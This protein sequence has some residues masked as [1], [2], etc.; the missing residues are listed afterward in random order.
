[1][2][3][4]PEGS[5]W[6]IDAYDREHDYR[7]LD[8]GIRVVA[9]DFV[10]LDNR[11]GDLRLPTHWKNY[12]GRQ[13]GVFNDG[14]LLTAVKL[15]NSHIRDEGD[16][17]VIGVDWTDQVEEDIIELAEGREIPEKIAK[18]RGI[19]QV[20][21]GGQYEVDT[22]VHDFNDALAALGITS[23]TLKPVEL[24]E[25]SSTTQANTEGSTVKQQVKNNYKAGAA[26]IGATLL[27]S[28]IYYEV[29]N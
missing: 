12:T 7:L 1:M 27:A 5:E 9:E 15:K 17:V 28:G 13:I 22:E 8:G 21:A 26:V 23:L 11:F 10:M 25:S 18:F 14:Q 20:Q 16:H 4:L 3:A 6:D 24:Q 2:P 19:E 29:A